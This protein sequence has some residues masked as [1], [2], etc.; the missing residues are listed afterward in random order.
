MDGGR[1]DTLAR[2]LTRFSNRRVLTRAL[3]GIALTGMLGAV[4][5]ENVAAKKHKRNKR[6]KKRN[7][8]K[9]IDCVPCVQKQNGRCTIQLPDDTTC[10]TTGRC[11]NGQCNSRPTCVPAGGLCP[12]GFAQCC[13][14][15]GSLLMCICQPGAAGRPCTVNGD[16]TSNSCIGYVCQ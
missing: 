5:P 12:D 8:K 10:N 2:T 3:S 9:R 14:G 4:W 11:L 1:F 16:C 6:K 15:Q 7:R 13:S